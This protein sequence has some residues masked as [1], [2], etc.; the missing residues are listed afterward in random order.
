MFRLLST[1][2]GHDVVKKIKKGVI[3]LSSTL[4]YGKDEITTEEKFLENLDNF[5]YV[6]NHY[7]INS[8]EQLILIELSLENKYSSILY[9]NIDYYNCDNYSLYHDAYRRM[10]FYNFY[11]NILFFSKIEP[12][13]NDLINIRRELKN[14]NYNV[15]KDMI[16]IEKILKAIIINRSNNLFNAFTKY[17]DIKK[18][19]Y[20]F[21]S[22]Q[23]EW[24]VADYYDKLV[25]SNF[26]IKENDNYIEVNNGSIIILNVIDDDK[27]FY[28]F[29]FG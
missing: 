3:K 8:I 21:Y 26:E 13:S 22:S 17:K 12:L 14:L 29:E 16:E 18:R 4:K 1:K 5:S 23:V 28:H 9:S 7:F 6:K 27:R 25:S 2:V 15:S 19:D 20:Q 10:F 24:I 11:E